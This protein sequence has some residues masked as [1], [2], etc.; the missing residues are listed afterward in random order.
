[1]MPF[2]DNPDIDLYPLLF[3]PEPP[4]EEAQTL[5]PV[6]FRHHGVYASYDLPNMKKYA[7]LYFT[8]AQPIQTF[9]RELTQK[10]QIDVD[11]VIALVF[12]G[13]DK[14]TEVH[15]TPIERY[16]DVALAAL[17]AKPDLQVVIQTDQQ[18]A[19]EA[20]LAAIPQAMFFE[21]LPATSGVKVIHNLAL[22]DEFKIGRLEFA[23]RML[24]V[25]HLLASVKY[26]VTH[27]GNVS[28]WLAC[29]RGSS[30]G[31]YQFDRDKILRGPDGEAIDDPAQIEWRQDQAASVAA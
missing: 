6:P 26:I 17:R 20:V 29:Y 11:K 14:S 25:T 21:E 1:M 5:P 18:Q 22:E 16:I 28:L 19:R 7:R 24:A 31:F 12:R 27:T 13:T 2:K 3:S 9:Q 10:Y 8:P 4:S 15:P 23:C 30:E